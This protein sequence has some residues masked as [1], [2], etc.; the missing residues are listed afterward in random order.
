MSKLSNT[1]LEACVCLLV[2]PGLFIIIILL[3]QLAFNAQWKSDHDQKL[4]LIEKIDSSIL[5]ALL[6]TVQAL[7][8]TLTSFAL[9]HCFQL[10]Q[11]ALTSGHRGLSYASI[12][13]LSPTTGL[14]GMIRLAL[15]FIFDLELSHRRM[16][17]IYF[18]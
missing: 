1:W 9:G 16:L 15:P 12:V 2:V 8:S 17:I 3:V 13:A 14:P 11:W 6:R 7:L 10:L 18:V 4:G 5:I